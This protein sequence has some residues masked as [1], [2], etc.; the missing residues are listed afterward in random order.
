MYACSL[1][2]IQSRIQFSR[3]AVNLIS[4]CIGLAVLSIT[5]ILNKCQKVRRI[6]ESEDLIWVTMENKRTMYMWSSGDLAICLISCL[7][8]LVL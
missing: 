5:V 6:N 8:V 2:V 4:G 3:Q 7:N 1:F